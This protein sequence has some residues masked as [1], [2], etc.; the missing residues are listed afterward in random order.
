MS[1]SVFPP[2][3]SA[4]AARDAHA[5]SRPRPRRLAAGGGDRRQ[6]PSGGGVPMLSVYYGN[7]QE[8]LLLGAHDQALIFRP[9]LLAWRAGHPCHRCFP[10]LRSRRY[11]DD[12]RCRLRR[13]CL[14][15]PRTYRAVRGR[16][17]AGAYMGPAALPRRSSGKRPAAHRPVVDGDVLR[18]DLTRGADQG[19]SVMGRLD[20]WSGPG[21]LGCAYAADRGDRASACSERNRIAQRSS[22]GALGGAVLSM[23]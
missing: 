10:G 8:S 19:R 4:V 12:C 14:P 2:V 3:H 1:S 7:Q 16:H 18:S 6:G 13:G 22:G 9:C 23:M 21:G 15:S 17:N 11:G 5:S 20:R